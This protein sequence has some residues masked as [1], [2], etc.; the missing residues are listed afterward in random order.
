E[1]AVGTYRATDIINR[2]SPHQGSSALVQHLLEMDP[3][4]IFNCIKHEHIQTIALVTSN[5]RPDK[6]SELLSLLRPELRDQA[7]ERLATLEPTPIEVLETVVEIMQRRLHSKATRGLNQTGGVKSAAD[8][9]NALQKNV[10]KSIIT[11]LEERNAEL[12]QAIRQK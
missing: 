3:R 11:S 8:V 4:Q 5:L 6:A 10:S 9:L 2:I 1:K 7:I 12:G